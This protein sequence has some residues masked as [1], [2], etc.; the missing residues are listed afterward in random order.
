MMTGT[1]WKLLA[2]G[3]FLAMAVG[4][5]QR[6]PI[7]DHP[8]S[9]PQPREYEC[10]RAGGPVEID[11]RIDDAAWTQAPWTEPFV[12]IE[13]A[14]KPKPRYQTRAKL[15]WDDE[16]LYI[17]VDMEE[18]HV[19][20]TLTQRDSIIFHDN[21]FEVFIDPD[22]DARDYYEVEVNALNTIFDLLLK[23]TYIDGGPALHDWNLRGLKTAVHVDGT[24]NDSSD[25][26]SGWSVEL[27]MPWEALGEY[28]HRPAPPHDGDT[29]RMNFSRV[30]WQHQLTDSTASGYEKVPDTAEN[31]WVWSPQG[32]INMH[33][34]QR[35]GY[36]RFVK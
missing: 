21:D 34:P 31:N 25:T 36:V 13:G 32:K 27:A 3:L 12:D 20:G 19:W 14:A 30:E 1:A 7:D 8:P 16:Y 4:C 10:Y 29:W 26:D 15:L 28:T 17:A 5:T 9:L 18:P 24:L 2:A 23:R 35:W 11:G 22:S 33:I 6:K